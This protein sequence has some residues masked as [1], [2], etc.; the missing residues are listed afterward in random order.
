[1]LKEQDT[2]EITMKHKYLNPAA[3]MAVDILLEY[4]KT[5]QEEC[6]FSGDPPENWQA[7]LAKVISFELL[8][9]ANATNA[10]KLELWNSL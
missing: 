4:L 8:T 3:E 1:M 9:A 10:D 7:G 6:P 5:D 2:Q